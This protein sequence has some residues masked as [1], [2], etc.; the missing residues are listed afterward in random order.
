MQNYCRANI[1]RNLFIISVC[2]L[3]IPDNAVVVR[4][5]GIDGILA[6]TAESFHEFN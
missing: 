3:E 2:L 5:V 6:A 1:Y 4:D